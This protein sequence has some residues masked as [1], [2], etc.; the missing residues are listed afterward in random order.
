MLLT[1]VYVSASLRTTV[2]RTR[3]TRHEESGGCV[4]GKG[5]SM[6]DLHE[7]NRRT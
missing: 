7:E 3:E 5:R 6:G 4:M 1:F 2:V